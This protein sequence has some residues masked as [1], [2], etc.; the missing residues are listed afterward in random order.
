MKMDDALY[1]AYLVEL[2]SLEKFRM[3]Y[4]A[5]HPRAPLGREDQDVRRLTEALA[6]FSAR[7]RLAGQRALAR[8][9][10]RLFRQHFPYVLN[11]VPAM[12]MLRALPQ[13]RCFVDPVELPRGTRVN[14]A[15][16]RPGVGTGALA[17][18]TLVPLRLNPSHLQRVDLIR[19]E[20]G[21]RLVLSFESH[22]PR[23]RPPGPLLLYVNHLNEFRSSLAV[24]Y[25]LKQTLREA[26]VFFDEPA[27]E[28]TRGLPCPRVRFGA[29][30]PSLADLEPFEH[31]LQRLCSFFHFPQ[32]ELFVELSLPTPP[33]Q[34]K[35][36]TVCLDL[37]TRWPTELVLTQDTFVLH[38]TPM[39]NLQ[40]TMATPLEHDGTRERHALQ[41]PDP[42]G[43]FRVHSV[44][45]VYR[46]DGQGLLPLRPAAISGGADTYEYEHESQ[47]TER[48]TWLSL[49]LPEAFTKPVRLAVD[50]CWYQPIP[51]ELDTSD[52]RVGLTDRFLEGLRWNTVGSVMPAQDNP[53]EHSQ[54]GLLELLSLRNQRFLRKE[55][56]RFLLEALGASAQRYFRPILEHLTEV[57]FTSKPFARSTTGFKYIYT[58]TFEGLDPLDVPT[59]DLLSARLRELL[60]TWS[61][62]DV[63]ELTVKLPDLDK[64][65]TYSHREEER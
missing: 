6:L 56:L 28:H 54:Q 62:E 53:L 27:S 19:R 63:V 23:G 5:L 9:T 2:E 7:T 64:T 48:R 52:Y 60:W 14:F 49:D 45:G 38:A 24:H 36:F 44:L 16:S 43:G 20:Q 39:V 30:L 37:K 59:V 21:D 31:P 1:K 26:S 51:P 40:Q 61:T 8:N 10:L 12:A 46:M 34:W 35:K 4:T 41:H 15:P 3:G 65:M 13:D 42:N 25:Q 22:F 11:P 50:A 18:R 29:P 17:F 55:D 32:Q 33:P 57:A 47:G 58:L